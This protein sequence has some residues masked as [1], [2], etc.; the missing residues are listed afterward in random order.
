MYL[1]FLIWIQAPDTLLAVFKVDFHVF[2]VLKECI[3]LLKNQL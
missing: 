2:F 3:N 1:R